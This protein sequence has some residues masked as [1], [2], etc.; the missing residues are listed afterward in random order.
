MGFNPHQTSILRQL[1]P[2][3]TPLRHQTDLFLLL[4][5]THHLPL[6]LGIY[7][8][9]AEAGILETISLFPAL[10][11]PEREVTI[12]GSEILRVERLVRPIQA[13]RIQTIP[14]PPQA[15]TRVMVA[16]ILDQRH[17][18]TRLVDRQL[19]LGLKLVH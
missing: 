15:A 10:L 2:D 17:L 18:V 6:G 5:Q 14:P 4:R 9:L 11:S 12:L 19:L 16:V 13:H 7:H 1:T 3:P 8:L